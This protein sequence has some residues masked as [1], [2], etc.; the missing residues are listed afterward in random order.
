M[1]VAAVPE[2]V[3]GVRGV[4]VEM[5]A[6][7]AAAELPRGAQCRWWMAAAPGW[8]GVRAPRRARARARASV[9]ARPLRCA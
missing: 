5:C 1:P 7:G 3:G 9:C 2:R 8:F 6:A 4:C